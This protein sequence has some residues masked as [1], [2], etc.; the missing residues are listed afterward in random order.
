VGAMSRPGLG[1]EPLAPLQQVFIERALAFRCGTRAPGVFG[2]MRWK[3]F[4]RTET[5][6]VV[7]VQCGVEFH[8][9]TGA[10]D[11]LDLAGGGVAAEQGAGDAGEVAGLDGAAFELHLRARGDVESRLDHAVVAE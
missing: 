3:R 10:F 11:D 8:A 4:P 5:R 7:G 1:T 2:S 6:S 9:R